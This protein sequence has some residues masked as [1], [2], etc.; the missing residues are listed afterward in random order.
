MRNGQKKL[1]GD[2]KKEFIEKFFD[3]C[4]RYHK[5]FFADYLKLGFFEKNKEDYQEK[6]IDYDSPTGKAYIGINKSP[7]MKTSTGIGFQGVLIQDDKR[8]LVQCS[9]CGKWMKKITDSHINKCSGKNTEEYKKEFGLNSTT[10]L[11]SDETS[12]K[13]TNACLRNK[14]RKNVEVNEKTL[15]NLKKGRGKKCSIETENRYGNCPLQLKTRLYDFI[16]CNREFPNCHNRGR[17]LYKA[18]TKRF[19][20]IGKALKHYGLPTFK[21]EGTTYKFTF[22]DETIYKINLNKFGEREMLFD[23]LVEKCKEFKKELDFS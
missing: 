1:F 18:I 11:V 4:D 22:P 13:C 21:R 7:F 20:R 2:R 9:Y 3:V 14:D 5:D 12:L 15:E 17:A 6:I 19:G 8:K 10:G 23:L 16:I